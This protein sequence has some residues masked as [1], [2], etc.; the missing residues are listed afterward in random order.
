[1]ANKTVDFE[2][3]L[4]EL[5]HLVEQMERGDATLDESLKAFERG[6]K[7]TRECQT[8]LTQAE[9]RVKKLAEDGA[10]EPLESDANEQ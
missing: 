2:A 8:A 3:T 6:V 7:L 9:L 4:E 1:M 10:L 5:A